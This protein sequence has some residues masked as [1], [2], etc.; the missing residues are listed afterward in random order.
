MT[1]AFDSQEGGGPIE[2]VTPDD[3][4]SL[5]IEFDEP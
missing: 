3:G 1:A 2:R 5:H 4:I